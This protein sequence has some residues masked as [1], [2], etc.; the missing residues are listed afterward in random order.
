MKESLKITAHEDIKVY[1]AAY[2]LS[3]PRDIDSAELRRFAGELMNS[4]S[5]SCVRHGGKV[6][7]HIKAY[8]EHR[9]GFLHAN[10]VGEAADV[11]VNGRDGNPTDR[12]RLV[13][14]SIVYG[15]S[16]ESLKAATV[17]GIEAASGIFG[18]DTKIDSRTVTTSP[19]QEGENRG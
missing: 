18:F 16:E 10:T 9:T 3:R 4:I 13:V 12:F 1:A 6:I 7:G 19:I 14:N 15:I 5:A 2:I 17:E 11:T 8:M